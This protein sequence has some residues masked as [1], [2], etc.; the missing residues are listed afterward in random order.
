MARCYTLIINTLPFR[1]RR[2]SPLQSLAEARLN[3]RKQVKDLRLIVRAFGAIVGGGG[4]EEG[5]GGGGGG[6]GGGVSGL[7]GWGGGKAGRPRNGG[8]G[9]STQGAAPP[10]RASLYPGLS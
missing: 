2:A 8:C 4:G 9:H 3:T 6:W 10:G 7:V 1:A 5:R